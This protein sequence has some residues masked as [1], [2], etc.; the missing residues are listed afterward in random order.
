MGYQSASNFCAYARM[1]NIGKE[2]VNRKKL[3]QNLERVEIGV[4]QDLITALFEILEGE[5]Y[6][7]RIRLQK[8]SWI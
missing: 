2:L 1:E 3:Q 5:N 4:W 7:E 8:F 6:R